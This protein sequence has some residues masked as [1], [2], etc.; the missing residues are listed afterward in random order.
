VAAPR[1]WDEIEDAAGLRQLAYSEVL[2]RLDH[3]GDLAEALFSTGPRVPA[4]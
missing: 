4:A 2:D 3:F 1:T